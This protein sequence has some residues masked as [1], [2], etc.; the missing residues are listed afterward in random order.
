M[1][2]GGGSC[3]VGDAG[4]E[5]ERAGGGEDGMACAEGCERRE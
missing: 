5:W 2:G 3:C 1:I 4:G